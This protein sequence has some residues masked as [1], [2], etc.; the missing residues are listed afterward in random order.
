MVQAFASLLTDP[1]AIRERFDE[2]S[3]GPPPYWLIILDDVHLIED[4][5]KE[6]LSAL[7]TLSTKTPLR[8]LMISRST[9]SFYDR[10]D[11]FTRKIVS[12]MPLKGLKLDEVKL[13]LDTISSDSELDADELFGKIGGHPLALELLE[14]YGSEVHGDWLKF[15]IR[16]YLKGCQ[17]RRKICFQPWLLA[18]NQYLGRI[19]QERLSGMA[20]RQRT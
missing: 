10:R 16:R 1:N 17:N 19:W 11:V 18:T 15:W 12:E 6:L 8:L 14:L 9:M 7:L 4:E 2:R 20:L 3:G 13:W 5:C